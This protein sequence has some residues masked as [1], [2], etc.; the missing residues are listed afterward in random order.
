LNRAQ[1]GR[2]LFSWRLVGGLGLLGIAILG[3]FQTL[4]DGVR[5]VDQFSEKSA[6]Q[7]EFAIALN[8]VAQSSDMAGNP[9]CD[10]DLVNDLDLMTDLES[11]EAWNGVDV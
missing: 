6:E 1:N 4:R 11:L 10:F 2:R 5:A 9:A 8:D 7:S 3:V